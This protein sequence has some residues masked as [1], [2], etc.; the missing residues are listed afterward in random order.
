MVMSELKT[1]V[2]KMLSTTYQSLNH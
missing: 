2:N 1:D